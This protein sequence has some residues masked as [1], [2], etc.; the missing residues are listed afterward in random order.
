MLSFRNTFSL[1]DYFFAFC[2]GLIL[3]LAFAPFELR[4]IAWVSPMVLFWLSLQPMSFWQRVRLAYVYGLGVFAGGA[5]WVYVSIHVYSFTPAPIAVLMVALFV[6]FLAILFIPFGVITALFKRQSDLLKLLVI[7]P[8]A[9]FLTEWLREWIILGG[10]PWLQ[11]GHTQLETPLAN[12]APVVGSLG[13][14]W[15]VALG[16]GALIAIVVTQLQWKVL[17]L[18]I[19]LG[20]FVAGYALQSKQWTQP[21]GDPIYVSLVQPNVA[22]E[23]KWKPE[24][25]NE[26]I[27]RQIDLTSQAWNSHLIIWPETGLP[28]YF[29]QS[30]DDVIRPLQQVA[31]E[32]QS[33]ILMGGF[34]HDQQTNKT[35]NAIMRIGESLDVYGKSRLVPFG[36]YIPMLDYIRWMESFIR[37]PYDSVD[38]WQGAKTMQVAGIPMR[39]SICYEDAYGSEMTQGLP[40]AKM[41]VNLTND[42]WF[43]GSIEV[44]Q[45]AEI[46]RWRAIETGRYLL[47]AT[48][49]GPSEIISPKGFVVAGSAAYKADLVSGY[50]QPMSGAT[51]YVR[52]G[53]YLLVSLLSGLLL[54]MWIWA[55]WRA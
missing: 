9:W 13:V 26:H 20:T 38:R 32:A 25:R 19:G 40:E 18:A 15:L 36:E 54:I 44:E 14:S 17:A 4:P 42:G 24:F 33:E 51:P 1:W 3:V 31:K 47:R 23:K 48:N 46:A 49:L 29:Q 43:T 39:L 8:A 53:N 30:M 50:A 45:H 16:A 21:E 7:F 28:D 10:F 52:W 22:Q 2:G 41:L 35:Y 27:Q 34:H 11:L 5:H 6:V 12:L 55:R 37:L